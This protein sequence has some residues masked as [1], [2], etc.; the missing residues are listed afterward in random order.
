M[1]INTKDDKASMIG[2]QPYDSS[3]KALFEENAATII[4][5]L[6]EGAVFVDALDVETLPPARRADRVFSIQYANQKAIADI[7]IQSSVDPTIASRMHAYFAYLHHKYQQA[8]FSI[9]VY[10]FEMTLPNSPLRVGIGDRELLNFQFIVVPLFRMQAHQYVQQHAI[11]MYP[12]LPAMQGFDVNI[13]MIAY[14]EM[15]STFENDE[16]RLARQLLWM[17][18]LLQRSSTISLAAKQEI[19]RRF[20]MFD[21]LMEEDPRVIQWMSEREARGEA[22]G[23]VEGKEELIMRL[24]E[25]RFPSLI[26]LAQDRLPLVRQDEELE[27]IAMLVALTSDEHA[28]EQALNEITA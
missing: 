12:L 2:N 17:G 20:N 1:L 23:R 6:L 9:A 10:P 4:P 21:R 7:E 25:R 15:S 26:H 24:I 3:L 22:R 5:Q 27:N 14:E 8:V 16:A 11:E 19:R 18:I 13:L 28:V